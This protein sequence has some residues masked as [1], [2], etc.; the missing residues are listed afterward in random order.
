MTARDRMILT[1]VLA[2]AA[3]GAAWYLAVAPKRQAAADLSTQVAAAAA[4]R[5]DATARATGSDR[6]R[7]TYSRD[8]ATIA[9]LGKAV[10]PRAD[11]ASLVFQLEAAARA[12]KVDFR[13]ITVE[14][15]PTVAPP[16]PPAATGAD[17]TSAAPAPAAKTTPA[18]PAA[19]TTDVRPQPFTFTFEGDYRGLRRLLAQIDRF[20]RVGGE[21]LAIS[22]RLLTIDSVTMLPGRKGLPQVKADI[23]AQ[24]YTAALPAEPTSA[25]APPAGAATATPTSTPAPQ[26]TP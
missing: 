23:V 16:A 13:S 25:A 21:K 7:A 24:A 4:R 26:V 11:V 5:D 20:S 15:P 19:P 10:P 9:R 6:A 17:E 8:Y 12:A 1:V 2:A 18:A 14:D 3:L 22:G